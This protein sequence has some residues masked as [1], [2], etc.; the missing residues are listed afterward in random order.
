[1]YMF[2]HTVRPGETLWSIVKGYGL[3]PL[4]EAINK[5]MVVNKLWRTPYLISGQK[6]N[7]P[8]DGLYY[9]VR[10]GDTLWA[11]SNRF[12]V[13]ADELAAM[14]NISNPALIYPGMVLKFHPAAFNPGKYLVCIDP[15]HQRHANYGT[16]PI[17]PGSSVMKQKVSSGT[18]GVVTGKPEYQL[19][20]EVALKVEEILKLIGYRVIMTRRTN[21][22]DLSNI[23]RAQIANNSGADVCVRIHADY[24]F[25]KDINGVSVQYPAQD[26]TVTQDVY[27]KSKRL[28]ELLLKNIIKETHA[29]SRGI[30]PRSDITGF[31][32]SKIP[33]ALVEMGFMSNPAEDV[34]MSTP[35]YQYKIAEGITEGIDEYLKLSDSI[36]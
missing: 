10:P 35:L 19:N 4:Y 33:V 11:M 24:S 22:V 20:L 28:A 9:V 6:L 5:I 14:N 21:D 25:D 16:E 7:I 32:W 18:Q 36:M 27:V 26:S 29:N 34:K 12:K 23:Q 17:A 2:T 13:P 15:G 1:M 8:I 3:N 31:N 30:V